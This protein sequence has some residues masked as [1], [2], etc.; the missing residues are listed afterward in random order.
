MKQTWQFIIDK[1]FEK[2]RVILLVVIDNK[3]SS[4]GQAGF[5]MAVA[6]D[7]SMIGSIGGGQTEFRLVED[8]PE[9]FRHF[10][11]SVRIWNA[12]TGVSV[13]LFPAKKRFV[14]M[15]TQTTLHQD[16]GT[17]TRSAVV[18]LRAGARHRR[19]HRGQR[20]R[21]NRRERR[22]GNWWRKIAHSMS[23]P[24]RRTG[25]LCCTSET[26]SS[27]AK[28]SGS[29]QPTAPPSPS[30]SSPRRR[31]SSFRLCHLMAAFSR[32][33]PTNRAAGRCG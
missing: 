14:K 19:R 12:K 4:P 21:R 31:A 28:T 15:E 29:F 18:R 3:G 30:P 1:L 33:P 32:T 16:G 2:E 11:P 27:T 13:S 10:K 26:T 20:R 5:K 8:P 7:G 22:R 25:V 17:E 23:A 6:S 24:G 9:E